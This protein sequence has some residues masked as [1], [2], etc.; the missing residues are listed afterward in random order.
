MLDFLRPLYEF[1]ERLAGA[2]VTDRA[3]AAIARAIATT[4]A[5]LR[6]LPADL[7][8]RAEGAPSG[9]IARPRDGVCATLRFSLQA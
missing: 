9:G 7:A 8:K 5:E 1:S 2:P 3:D 4:E 6:F